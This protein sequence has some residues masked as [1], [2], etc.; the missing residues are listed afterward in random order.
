MLVASV[1]TLRTR[2]TLRSQILL[3]VI[4]NFRHCDG[5]TYSY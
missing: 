2:T 4:L 5:P 1:T 3:Q